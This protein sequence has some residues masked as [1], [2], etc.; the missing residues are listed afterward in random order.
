MIAALLI[1][2]LACA[3][4]A[5]GV[6]WGMGWDASIPSAVAAG[7]VPFIVLFSGRRAKPAATQTIKDFKVGSFTKAPPRVPFV[8]EVK[9]Q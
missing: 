7:T 5:W 8:P 2:T 3:L 9:Q 1:F 6:C 4:S